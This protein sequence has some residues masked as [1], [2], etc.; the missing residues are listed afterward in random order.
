M[1]IT[2]NIGQEEGRLHCLAPLPSHPAPV[3]TVPIMTHVSWP[4][5]LQTRVYVCF[6]LWL[7]SPKLESGWK[8]TT[9]PTPISWNESISATLVGRSIHWVPAPLPRHTASLSSPRRAMNY[10]LCG[11]AGTQ[12][13]HAHWK[14]Q[15]PALLLAMQS[16][17]ETWKYKSK[18]EVGRI[19][20][21]QNHCGMLS[22][23]N[24]QV[25]TV[26]EL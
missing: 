3:C 18:L 17:W 23:K 9:F 12:S 15:T 8:K 4:A 6:G 11:R 24:V 20:S 19:T 14:K 13:H 21:S 10:C 26:S 16:S 2:I 25:L 5:G 1:K 22:L 7:Q